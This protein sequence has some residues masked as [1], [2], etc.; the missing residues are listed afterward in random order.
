LTPNSLKLLKRKRK[1][2]S[3]RHYPGISFVTRF[4]NPGERGKPRS[5]RISEIG[6]I[7]RIRDILWAENAR[8]A[9]KVS[10]KEEISSKLGRFRYIFN[11]SYNI[12]IVILTISCLNE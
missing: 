5:G 6:K 11:D 7:N 10:A 2:R 9:G 3:Q 8:H 12:H 4:G 1:R